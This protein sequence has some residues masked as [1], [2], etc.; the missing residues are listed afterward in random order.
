MIIINLLDIFPSDSQAQLADKINYNLNQLLRLGLG[1]QGEQGEQ[2][3]IGMTGPIGPI[4]PTGTRGSLWFSGEYDSPDD[5]PNMSASPDPKLVN[6]MYMTY[7]AG[8]LAMWQ[9]VAGSPDYWQERVNIDAILQGYISVDSPFRRIGDILPSWANVILPYAIPVSGSWES[10]LLMASER[11]DL[12]HSGAYSATNAVRLRKTQ[13]AFL[14]GQSAS[15]SHAIMVGEVDYDYSG[16]SAI[17]ANPR[18]PSNNSMRISAKYK[19]SAT[20][21]VSMPL[22]AKGI[23]DMY[24]P[25]DGMRVDDATTSFQFDGRYIENG[26]SPECRAYL[27]TS[28]TNRR[29]LIGYGMSDLDDIIHADLNFAGTVIRNVNQAGTPL[30]IAIG[31]SMNLDYLTTPTPWAYML[32]N[33]EVDRIAV[34][35]NMVPY[36]STPGKVVSIGAAG[37]SG[38]LGWNS[39]YVN[40]KICHDY[41]DL[42][43]WRNSDDASYA[44]DPLNCAAAFTKEGRFVI[45]KELTDYAGAGNVYG[46]D[47][48]ANLTSVGNA[49]NR[50]VIHVFETL[51][52]A[53]TELALSEAGILVEKKWAF[54]DGY[55]GSTGMKHGASIYNV[56]GVT[57]SSAGDPSAICAPNACALNV[58]QGQESATPITPIK[59]KIAQMRAISAAG[60]AAA[61]ASDITI[62]VGID[63]SFD[64]RLTGGNTSTNI[65][66]YTGVKSTVPEKILGVE[67]VTGTVFGMAAKYGYVQDG[68]TDALNYI[69]GHLRFGGS[70]SGYQM[71]GPSGYYSIDGHAI[72]VCEGG[73]TTGAL[74][75]SSSMSTS[76]TSGSALTLS[77]GACS[78]GGNGGSVNIYG[79]GIYGSALGTTSGSVNVMSSISFGEN[80]TGGDLALAG[81][82]IIGSATNT[83]GLVKISP[84]VVSADGLTV[85]SAGDIAI[86]YLN[87]GGTP[88]SEGNVGFGTAAPKEKIHLIGDMAFGANNAAGD[89]VRKMYVRHGKV[90]AD[91]DA[92]EICGTGADLAISAGSG[93]D[94]S[95]IATTQVGG[96]VYMYGGAGAG[97]SL[98]GQP[99][100][101]DVALCYTEAGVALGRLGVG[102]AP[103][104]SADELDYVR[105]D[106]NGCARVSVDYLTGSDAAP[107]WQY[108]L[109]D[110]DE[111][112]TGMALYV[113]SAIGTP[114][115]INHLTGNT[116]KLRIKYKRIGTLIAMNISLLIK[117]SSALLTSLQANDKLGIVL[118]WN[119][120][121][122]QNHG[123]MTCLYTPTELE[124][125]SRGMFRDVNMTVTPALNSPQWSPIPENYNMLVLRF[126]S[127]IGSH[128][129]YSVQAQIMYE[130]EN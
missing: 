65:G 75:I 46:L 86:G 57:D 113:I 88:L 87:I 14:H 108:L 68:A 126:D 52:E 112:P 118:A 78:G 98:H 43:V 105:A 77:A 8:H 96:N 121:Q 72:H 24:S 37:E 63:S 31:T 125:N 92:D 16:G 106:I 107:G 83:P 128:T 122:I 85:L 67:H 95:I 76:V 11:Q 19:H 94:A 100:D 117:G 4:G 71:R 30:A 123:S 39:V 115:I 73:G 55:V 25:D 64:F 130:V 29:S 2:G 27:T 23:F 69:A 129:G 21:P 50:A 89:Q 97:I 48:G 60:Y 101:G 58:L 91:V 119:P 49:S 90:G 41:D 35:V 93:Y 40:E 80:I 110:T 114:T 38:E 54:L 104:S 84:S 36:R 42:R 13:T 6:D 5:D 34:N 56:I 61:N 44:A 70:G 33:S 45:G 99:Y 22:Y 15:E 66:Y 62:Y 10:T 12:L 32:V 28:F 53:P 124:F 116:G 120:A 82:T 59:G 47:F 3:P 26:S 20:P 102:C 9:Y 109:N 103:G 1:E 74:T 81:A 111:L 51:D 79:G 17:T 7:S 18:V 127:A